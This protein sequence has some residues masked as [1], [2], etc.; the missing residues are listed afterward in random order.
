MDHNDEV[1]FEVESFNKAG[2][3]VA[4][5]TDGFTIDHTPPNLVVIQ[6]NLNG[7]RYQTN[8][9]LLNLRWRFNDNESGIKE[10][11]YT[12]FELMYG[13]KKKV[14]PKT[15]TYFK[16]SPRFMSQRIDLDLFERLI[17]G[18]TYSVKVTAINH[19][20][21]SKVHESNGVTIDPTPPIMIEVKS[22]I[23]F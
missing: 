13:I 20:Q 19:A 5:S 23:F 2:L 22:N 12:V 17:P 16:I 10:Y 8:D 6:D 11:R 15:T 14:W 7:A 1:H 4:V 18:A 3:S 9:S 21:L